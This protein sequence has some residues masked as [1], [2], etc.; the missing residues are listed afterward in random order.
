[1]KLIDADAL[2]QAILSTMPERSEVLLIVDNQPEGIVR[3][4]DCI[5]RREWFCE[6]D[7]KYHS[8]NFFCGFGKRKEGDVDG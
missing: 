4:K 3:C 8:P 1:M 2:R 7:G 6:L 5:K